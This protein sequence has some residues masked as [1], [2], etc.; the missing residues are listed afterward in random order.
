M[1]HMLGN[2]YIGGL[3][4]TNLYS[5]LEGGFINPRK[6]QV[7]TCPNVYANITICIEVLHLL[8]YLS[9]TSN[10]GLKVDVLKPLYLREQ[11]LSLS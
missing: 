2:W 5:G 3:E 10:K 7:E 11:I 8:E 1:R 6:K 9:L 4:L